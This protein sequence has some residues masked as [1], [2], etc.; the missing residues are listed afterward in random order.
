MHTISLRVAPELYIEPSRFEPLLALLREN[1]EHITEVAF[2]TGYTHPPLPLAT[3]Q[4]VAERLGR[5]VIPAVRAL[6]LR[7]GINHLATLGHLD[8]E[9]TENSLQEPWQNL[10]DMSGAESTSCYCAADPRVQKYIS[11]CY[12]ALA[13]SQPD[14]IWYEWQHHAP[15][16]RPDQQQL[17]LLPFARHCTLAGRGSAA[18]LNSTSLSQAPAGP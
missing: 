7:A 4:R 18:G 16:T 14:F 1:R 15:F 10:V 9:N 17:H 12:A 6:G 8:D 5:E 3:I 13:A 2:F 11:Q